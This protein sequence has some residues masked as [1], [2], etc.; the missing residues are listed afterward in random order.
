M[1]ANVSGATPVVVVVLLGIVFGN[2][3]C[4]RA[5][6]SNQLLKSFLGTVKH[7]VDEVRGVLEAILLR[8]FFLAV[9]AAVVIGGL[10]VFVFDSFQPG[11]DVN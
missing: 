10:F 4:F 5:A 9:V 8:A 2:R 1:D 6:R 7:V 11:A 3:T